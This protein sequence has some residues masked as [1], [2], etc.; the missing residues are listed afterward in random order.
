MT[1]LTCVNI[2]P[3][4][5][6][7]DAAFPRPQATAANATWATNRMC[8]ESVLVRTKHWNKHIPINF[9]KYLSHIVSCNANVKNM[10]CTAIF[11]W[12][13]ELSCSVCWC[14]QGKSAKDV[15]HFRLI[16]SLSK[17]GSW[18]FVCF[19]FHSPDVDEC[20]SNPCINGDCVNTPGSY[21]CKC[22]EGYQGTPTKQACIGM[23]G[24]QHLLL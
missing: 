23:S 18:F 16:L 15:I 14:L 22:H 6:W 13:K 21:N 2:S 20:V 24:F 9:L 7:M 11:C 4:C 19:L 17:D 12:F 10:H 1:A 3:T 8:V 5:V